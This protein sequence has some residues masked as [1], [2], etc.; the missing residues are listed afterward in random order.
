MC[1]DCRYAACNSSAFVAFPTLPAMT[2]VVR[3]KYQD[4][5]SWESYGTTAFWTNAGANPML[6]LELVA[7][8]VSLAGC[9]CPLETCSANITAAI[10]VLKYGPLAPSLSD[11]DIAAE[12]NA[13]KVRRVTMHA[14]HNP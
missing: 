12:F 8:R 3:S 14:S 11:S 10:L 9:L 6:A 5:N 4:F 7:Q 1:S 2:T 13:F